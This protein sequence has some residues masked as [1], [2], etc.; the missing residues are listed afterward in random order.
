MDA[1]AEQGFYLHLNLAG[2]LQI[3]LQHPRFTIQLFTR[4]ISECL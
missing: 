1:V 4:T 3:I 2:V